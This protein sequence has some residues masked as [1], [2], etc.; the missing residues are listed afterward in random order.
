MSSN[1]PKKGDIIINPKTSRPVKV[2]SRTWLN[3]VKKGLVSGHYQDPNELYSIQENDNVEEKIKELNNDLPDNVQSVRG[4]GKYKNKIVKRRKQ[5]NTRQVVKHTA[6][7]AARTVSK[8]IRQNDRLSEVE[9]LELQLENMIMAE[10]MNAESEYN[11]PA[12]R[13]ITTKIKRKVPKQIN[14]EDLEDDEE[15]YEAEEPQEYYDDDVEYDN[16]EYYEE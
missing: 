11:Q 4:R 6:K 15:Y 1:I 2:G 16:E 3:L 8:S 13:R 9:D 10:M 12:P 5:P 7:T 14:I